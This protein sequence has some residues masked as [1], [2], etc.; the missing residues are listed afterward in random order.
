MGMCGRKCSK[1]RD[2]V[3]TPSETTTLTTSMR[4]VSVSVPFTLIPSLGV[5]LGFAAALLTLGSPQAH[6]AKYTGEPDIQTGP[7][8]PEE[9]LRRMRVEEGLR[10]ELVAAEPLITDPADIAFDELGRMFVVEIIGYNRPEN[11]R[12]RS[13]IRVLHD[14]D[15][16][17]R[18]DRAT[19]FA[20]DLDYAQGLLPIRGGLVVTTNTGILFLRDDDNDGRADF[21]EVLFE[22]SPSINVDRQ[23]S[24]PRRG[25]DNWIYINLGLFKK[26]LFRPAAPDRKLNLT[27]NFRYHP[28]T[29]KFEA[30]S[31]AGQFGKAFDDWGRE[32]FSMNRNPGLFAVLPHRYVERNPFA[33]LTRSD[34]DVVPAGGDGKVYPLQNFRTTSS[35]HAGTFT[36]ACGTGVY[37]GDWLG[38][39]YAGN[40][41]VCEPTRALVSRWILEP[42]GPSFRAHRAQPGQEF[43]AS[44]DEWFRPVNTATGPD[45]AFYVVDMYRRFIDGARFFP[46]DYRAKNDMGARGGP[47]ADL[48]HRAESR[49]R[50]APAGRVAARAVEASCLARASQRLAAR[51]RTAPAGRGG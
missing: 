48:S 32:F 45:G 40:L 30:A 26:E 16:D 47:G 11:A 7:L 39:E 38:P 27:T 1:R 49:C 22:C 3:Q 41:F 50:S 10:I 23:M 37:R 2:L 19:T 51:H 34:E 4:S 20:E 17:G 14:D 36:A 6:A 8:S 18:M 13:R 25:I 35:A 28:G 24:A 12:P 9:S 5:T 42:S 33:F 29:G 21:R 43:L 31:G 44:G 46:D 15:G